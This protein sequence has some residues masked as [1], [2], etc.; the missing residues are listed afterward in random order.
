MGK[1][2]Y[3]YNIDQN[4]FSDQNYQ[5]LYSQR[6]RDSNFAAAIQHGDV[7]HAFRDHLGIAPLY[8]R[9][10][11]TGSQILFSN[12]LSSLVQ[13]TDTLLADGVYAYLRLRTPR[14]HSLF[15]E[16]HIVPPGSVIE[17]SLRM[18]TFKTIYSYKIRPTR[19]SKSTSLDDL[20]DYFGCLVLRSV[21]QCLQ[22]DK[23]GIYLSGGIDSAL[24]ALYL[25]KLGV[26]I[27]A[28][29]SG[30][31][32]KSSSDIQYAKRNAD[33]MGIKHHELHYLETSDYHS[34]IASLP[35][36][37][38]IP[39]GNPPSLGVVKMWEKTT[40]GK[41]QQLFFGQNCDTMFGSMRALYLTYFLQFMPKVIRRRFHP[42]LIFSS[43]VE[44]YVALATNFHGNL[45]Q[46]S[47]PNGTAANLTKVQ[48]LIMAGLYIVQTP[49][50]NETFTQ[51]SYMSGQAICS[52]YHNMD[53]V[54]Y[55]MGL[56]LIRRFSLD[57]KRMPAFEK[58]V[59]RKLATRYFP[60]EVIFQ[61]KAFMVS[62]DRDRRSRELYASF[63]KRAFGIALDYP[64][65]RFGGTML[66]RW[67]KR[68]KVMPPS[69]W[70]N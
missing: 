33:L 39:H 8:F 59:V 65:E 60:K 49:H 3:S 18:R 24:V 47:L 25:K 11:A 38:G 54:E 31:W 56:A 7:I 68:C 44:N 9:F 57:E 26:E 63:P 12:H 69:N 10:A 40:V 6:R 22:Y 4:M 66:M 46:L 34:A 2:L 52:P 42:R 48:N 45:D 36:R 53:L 41:Q 23:V 51:L 19:V 55:V 64:H 1:L 28:Y 50:D 16:I 14:L 37:F 67:L 21:Q 32:G 61:K 43:A 35:S 27:F 15:N 20:A 17:I 30:S 62:F 58:L 13:P 29:T 5:S 70:R